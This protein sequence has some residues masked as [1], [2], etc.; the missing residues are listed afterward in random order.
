MTVHERLAR[1]ARQVAAGV[2]PPEMDADV[3]RARARRDRRRRAS[4][5]TAA[6][7][8]VV[9]AVVAT[10][11][12]GQD[13]A[14]PG[15]VEP[16]PAPSPLETVTSLPTPGETDAFPR[17][18]TPE[19]V[20]HHPRAQLWTAAVA[21]GDPDTRISMWLVSCVRPCRERGPFEFTAA[22]TTTDG[23]KTT[24]YLRP[25]FPLG[26]DLHVSTPDDGVFL[27]SDQSNGGEWLVDTHGDVRAVTRVDSV[28]RP[29]DPRLWFQCPGR[30]RSTWCALDVATA[31]AYSWPGEW[32]GSAATPASGD[33]PWGTNP[34]PRPTSLSGKLEAWWDATDG[35]QLR[36]LTAT[37]EGD[38]ILGSPPGE[39]AYWARSAGGSDELV[40]YTSRN[41]GEDWQVD[42]R[43]AG[44]ELSGYL[45]MHRSPDGAY[46]AYRSYPRLV[47][48]RAEASGGP[49]RK[50]YE[51]EDERSPET[52]G[53]GLWVQDD[54]VYVNANATAAVS[55]DDGLTWTTV[56]TWR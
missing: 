37:T 48:W 20:V 47:V 49:F 24:I 56:R 4:L 12:G 46:L 23:Y 39:M 2:T 55:A 41:R 18:M 50:V 29:S 43:T 42:S 40:I 15:L 21:P 22:A 19:E 52:S 1:A 8:V 25:P 54:L 17:S 38:Y 16:A 7:L 30:W 10:V 28:L 35:R 26:V 45:A 33:R 13:T 3:V 14:A 51:Q 11:I 27:I 6:T 44:P 53:A 34:K 31:T 9:I 5:T 36:T 32:D